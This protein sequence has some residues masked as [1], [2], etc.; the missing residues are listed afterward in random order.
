MPSLLQLPTSDLSNAKPAAEM[1]GL[2]SRLTTPLSFMITE[3]IR[4][5]RIAWYVAIGQTQA[6]QAVSTSEASHLSYDSLH[7]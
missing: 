2:R 4:C 3:K 7:E 6:L 5:R 1:D